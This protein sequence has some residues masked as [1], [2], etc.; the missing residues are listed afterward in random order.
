[1]ASSEIKVYKAEAKETLNKLKTEWNTLS[2]QL[3]NDKQVKNIKELMQ[4]QENSPLGTKITTMYHAIGYAK[5]A[6][7]LKEQMTIHFYVLLEVLWI[8]VL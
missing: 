8:G 3:E 7:K 4:L 5:A 2:S 1:M 6:I